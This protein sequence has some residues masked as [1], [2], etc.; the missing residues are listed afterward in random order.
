MKELQK[1]IN[2]AKASLTLNNPVEE[3]SDVCG[4]CVKGI[5]GRSTRRCQILG[6][7]WLEV[8]S[9]QLVFNLR[10]VVRQLRNI[11]DFRSDKL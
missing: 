3:E 6:V 9:D 2:E 8:S 7:L 5:P 1:R 11:P 4:H 10:R